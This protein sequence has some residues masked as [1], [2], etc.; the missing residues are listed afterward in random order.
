[1]L[2]NQTIYNRQIHS[3][4]FRCSQKNKLTSRLCVL[5]LS[6]SQTWHHFERGNNFSV[7]MYAITKSQLETL[8]LVDMK[9]KSA[10]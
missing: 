2:C 4:S 10:L 5:C 7:C 1:M 3:C 6:F 8:L 9:M